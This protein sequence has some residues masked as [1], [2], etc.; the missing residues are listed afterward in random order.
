MAAFGVST[1][2]N[3]HASKD[4]S[5][6]HP[7]ITSLNSL[8][9]ESLCTALCLMTTAFDTS[10]L[11]FDIDTGRESFSFPYLSNAAQF[12]FAKEVVRELLTEV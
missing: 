8:T 10:A 1:I 12:P 7:K 11:S 3:R 5:L 6:V 9:Q 4:L 2:T